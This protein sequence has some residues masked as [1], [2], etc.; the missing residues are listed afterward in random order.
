MSK[1]RDISSAPKDKPVLLRIDNSA[2]E[3]E[4]DPET[5]RDGSSYGPGKWAVVTLNS[6]GCSCCSS[7]NPD[8][9][10]WMPLPTV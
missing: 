10:H 5:T 2:I 4:W 6:H 3:G 8:P 9:T 7:D 1:W